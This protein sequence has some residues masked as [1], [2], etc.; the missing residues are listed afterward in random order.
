MVWLGM[1]AR[2]LT[3]LV[4]FKGSVNGTVYREK[5][6]KKVVLED[7]LQKKKK[8]ARGNPFMSEKCSRGIRT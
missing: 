8:R 6:L 7:V 1:S 5:V 3:L 4:H 2:A